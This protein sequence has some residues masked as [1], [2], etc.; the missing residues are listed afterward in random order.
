M[1]TSEPQFVR[2]LSNLGSC[3]R[4]CALRFAAVSSLALPLQISAA[5]VDIHGP[6]G[7]V[8]FGTT[9]TALANGNFVVTDP[10][11]QTSDLGAVFLYSA[12]GTLISTLTGSTANDHVGGGGV[13]VVGSGNFVVL[14]PSWNNTGATNAGAVTWV[15]GSS[16]LSG[17]VS[18]SNSLVGTTTGD[19]ISLDGVTVL[20]DGNYV[21]VSPNWNN[22]VAG[23]SVGAATWGSGNSGVAGSVSVSNSL[24]GTTAFD[25]VGSGGITTLSNGNYVVATPTWHN[26]GAANVFGAATWGNGSSGITGIVSVSNSLVG[27]TAGDMVSNAGIVALSNGNYV[28]ASDFWNNGVAGSKFGAATWGNG[29]SGIIGPVSTSNSLIGNTN[30]DVVGFGSVTALSNGNYVVVSP[31][32]NNAIAGGTFGAVTWGDGSS[33]TN[34]LVSAGN[35]LIGSTMGDSVGNGGVAALS[36]GNFVISSWWWNNGVAN[37]KFGAATW[38]NGSSGTAA[39]VSASNSLIGTTDNDFVGAG[40]VTALSNGNYVVRSYHWGNAVANS[41]V[42][43]ATWGNGAT[44]STGIVSAGNSLIGSYANDSVGYGGVTAL[45]NGNYVV[46][47]PNWSNSGAGG[48]IG[49]ATWGNGSS[50]TSGP[51]SSSNSLTGELAGDFVGNGGL[52]ALSS[53]NYVVVSPNWNNGIMSGGF[54]AVTWGNGSTGVTAPVSAG[55]SLIGALAGDSV[56]FGVATAFGDGNYAVAS[57]YWNGEFG[58]VTLANGGFRLIGK[59][60]SWNSVVGTTDDGGRAMSYAYAPARHELI[61]GRSA[62]NIVS[63]F[64]MDQIFANDF[65]Q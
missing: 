52:V 17:A 38:V 57:T 56:G 63:L 44:G 58:A 42:G 12:T 59:I 9:V 30:G 62:S 32:W 18:A 51:V 2:F 45:R 55:N 15:N 43:A 53:G 26:G 19:S 23:N 3:L 13:V 37:S 49:A 27:T 60:Q 10:N 61:V 16:G 39:A 11:G 25:L 65:E 7:T 54:G 50:G 41:Q 6:S 35:S 1:L 34:G 40:G 47:S 48:N 33:G 14:S 64:T 31:N 29:S 28:V 8:A 20:N 5:Q 46:V 21:V 22:G 4:T 36:N 24:V